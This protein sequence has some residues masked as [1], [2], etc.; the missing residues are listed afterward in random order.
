MKLLKG[1]LLALILL[2]VVCVIGWL[3]F[4]NNVSGNLASLNQNVEKNWENYVANLKE[5]NAEF[6]QQKIASDSLKYYSESSKRIIDSK[7]Y[8]KELE[9]NEYK[10]NKIAMSNS[11]KSNLNE[12]L[13][14]S[15]DNYNQA[16]R[17]Y[18]VYRIRFPN[19]IIARRMNFRKSYKYFDIRYGIENEKVMARKK[20]MENWVKNGGAYPQ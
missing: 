10:F 9:L 15:L 16:V 2:V 13:N 5:R 7:D 12:K 3:F 17:D 11:F 1:C 14:S 4:E 19:S 6:T 8:L 18:N 20:E